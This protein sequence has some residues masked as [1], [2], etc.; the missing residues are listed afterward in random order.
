M[1]H[2]HRI[3][4]VLAVCNLGLEHWEGGASDDVLV[5]HDLVSV[6]QVGWGILYEK[7]GLTAARQL[8]E[9]LTLV[10][11]RDRETQLALTRLRRE[12]TKHV[13]A[14]VPWRVRRSLEVIAD[15]DLLAWAGLVGLLDECPVIHG[16]VRAASGPKPLSVS[17][18]AFDFVSERSQI[19]VV[20]AF[21]ASLPQLLAS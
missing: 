2:R 18:T 6:F 21:M 12:L 3:H 7:V 16:A 9:V 19:L 1:N 14:G 17:P 8:I 5:V 10:R 4:A 11:P 13:E 20:D 15:L